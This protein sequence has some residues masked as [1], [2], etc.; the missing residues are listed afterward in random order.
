MKPYVFAVWMTLSLGLAGLIAAD[1]VSPGAGRVKHAD[2]PAAAALVASNAVIVLDVRT[3][4]EFAG[5]H[6]AGATNIDFLAGDF[7]ERVAKLAREQAY[8]VHCAS[9]RRSTNCLP[10]L[11]RLGFTNLVHLDGGITAWRAAGLSVTK[12]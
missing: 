12:P 10:Q 9:G 6:I 4:K 3:P 8:L 2:A 5:G 1:A 7:A 11:Q